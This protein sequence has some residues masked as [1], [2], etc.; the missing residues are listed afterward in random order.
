MPVC[1][2]LLFHLKITVMVVN[3][4]GYAYICFV[5]FEKEIIFN[6]LKSFKKYYLFDGRLE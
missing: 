5:L 2:I 6:N 4:T 1:H 3:R